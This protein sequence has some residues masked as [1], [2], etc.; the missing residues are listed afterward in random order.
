LKRLFVSGTY[1]SQW[2]RRG[3]RDGCESADFICSVLEGN[4]IELE[5]QITNMQRDL[6]LEKQ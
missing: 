1:M 5:L 2:S 3:Q 4:R 6:P